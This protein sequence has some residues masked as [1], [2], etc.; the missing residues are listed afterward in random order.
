MIKYNMS[1]FTQ[2]EK[3]QVISLYNRLKD[4]REVIKETSYTKEELLS[5]LL[6]GGISNQELIK[7]IDIP[8]INE[9]QI[10]LI[11]DTHLGSKYSN[12]EY[13]HQ[14]YEYAVSHNIKTI[15]HLGDL[16]QSTIKN[17]EPQFIEPDKQLSI[18]ISFFNMYPDI[19]TYLLFGNHDLHL[20]K[21]DE[22][23]NQELLKLSNIK[24]LGFKKSYITWKNTIISLHHPISKYNLSIPY[25]KEKILLFGHRHQL[26]IKDNKIFL[27]T[28]SDDLKTYNG[29][30][31]KPGFLIFSFT[32][33]EIKIENFELFTKQK[34][35]I[36]LNN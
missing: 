9:E 5:I 20:L 2:E 32:S 27:P 25:L 8:F 23:F 34:K 30:K 6:V 10:I 24:I 12:L 4:L 36:Y 14:V 28:L 11:S 21:K 17:V 18:A 13:L 7:Y 33:K 1:M 19:T 35:L 16:F 22:A 3:K 26:Y 31:G 15:I 29:D